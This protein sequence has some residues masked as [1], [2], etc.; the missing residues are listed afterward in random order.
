MALH[1][2][3]AWL[4]PVARTLRSYDEA[5]LRR[6]AA[7][8][9]KP[10]GQWPVDE[11][12]DRCLETLANPTALD[13]RLK[14]LEPA[15][16]QVLALIGHSRQ[17]R[18]AVG[19]LVE[20]LTALGHGDGLT[21]VQDLLEAGLL[22][23]IVPEPIAPHKTRLKHF[24]VWL[25]HSPAP[26]VEAP[27]AVTQRALHEKL[28]AIAVESVSLKGPA[29]EAD[30]LDWP[31]RLAA[32]WQQ[33][34]ATPMRRTQQRDFFKR[35]LD[36]LRGDGLLGTPPADALSELP[37]PGLFA[38][39]LAIATG[40]IEERDGDL[41][42]GAFSLAWSG[43]G[44][45]LAAELLAALPRLAGW[46]PAGGWQPAAGPGNPHPAANLLALLALAQLPEG[47]WIQPRALETWLQEHHPFWQ[48]RT[49]APEPA[50]RRRKT[51]DKP[52]PAEVTGIARFLLGV[53][54][55]LR[56]LQACPDASG[57]WAVRL[58]ALGRWALGF[59]DAPPRAAV[60][61]QTL[62]VQP[63]LEILAYRQGL[64]PELIVR[65][66]RFAT[67]KT[68]GAACTLQLEPHSV[69]RALE[70]G[71]TQSSIV[72][73]LE[74]HSMKATPAPVLEAFKTWSNKRERISVYPAAVLLEF[75]SAAE[76]NEALARGLP[77]VRLTERLAAVTSEKHIDF[78]HFR[79]TGARDYCLPPEPCA[80]VEADGVTVS[81]DLARS[82]LLVESQ[83]QRFAELVDGAGLPGRRVYR[84]T[85]ASLAAG[86]TQ[87]LTLAALAEWFEQR[88]GLPLAPAARLL[89]SSGEAPPVELRRQLVLHVATAAI[90]DGL[91]QWPA[92]AALIQSRIGPTAF[93]VAE[94]DA[95]RLR[96]RLQEI[97]VR[98]VHEEG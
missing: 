86:R 53:A 27:P 66:T 33:L 24:E 25:G 4:E 98:M 78:K 47:H 58:S 67:W 65:L 29:R 79:L 40:V 88:T 92:T 21:P 36:R 91:L 73:T 83:V 2:P 14:E 38:A 75:P 70:L 89:F 46:N 13:R 31:L 97:G 37:D 1:S 23:P 6:V 64:S 15:A 63:N 49:P 18:W 9:C 55:P 50:S 19:S 42:A 85:P 30:G 7:R 34:A 22:F 74:R 68:L 81:I 39:A 10:R 3:D 77:G 84:L 44:V 52:P 57:A 45:A 26:Q 5:L 48:A 80:S 82:D 28:P 60:F 90:A 62:L 35:D 59:A 11:L 16:R 95:P 54:Y 96:E 87:G 41:C 32:L 93:A 8:L 56:L 17:P 43:D 76:L 72:Q 20:M 51:T 71:E 69:Y 61:P 94:Q 12:L